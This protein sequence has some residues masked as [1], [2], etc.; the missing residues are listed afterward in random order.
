ML[1]YVPDSFG[2]SM[3][4][5]KIYRGVGIDKTVF[6][7][8]L[9]TD[10]YPHRE[11]RW[12]SEDGSDVFFYNIR[13][14]YYVGGQL[15]Y[16]DDAVSLANQVEKGCLS[17]DIALPLG[18]DQRYVDRN[19]K[20]RIEQFNQK[21]AEANVDSQL[22]ESSYDALFARL[23]A[24]DLPMD[25][26]SGEMIDGQVSKIHRSIYSSRADHKRLNDMLERR[27]TLELEPLM[28]LATRFGIGYQKELL[29]NLWRIVTRNHAHD[30]AGGCNTDK[31]NKI[32]VERFEH[33]DQM[34]SAARDY[35]V[36]KVAESQQALE[37]GARLTLF[38]TLP[39]AREHSKK[40]T[41]STKSAGFTISTLTGEPVH[42]DVIAQSQHYNGSIQ[43]DPKDNDPN[44]YYYQT[45]IVLCHS[46]PALGFTSL[47]IE[48]THDA[49]TPL[50][51]KATFHIENNRYRIEYTGGGLHLIDK[52]N[53]RR[54]DY[55]L[56]ARDG[57]DDG[58]TYDYSP[59][60]QDWVID[61]SFN[62]A[63]CTTQ[64]GT[65]QHSLTLK[66]QWM[67]P[68]NLEARAQ[69]FADTQCDYVL[70][71]TLQD[72]Q[73]LS[74]EFDINNYV[75]DHRLQ[76]VVNSPIET[77]ES[78]A[79]TPFGFVRRPHYQLQ[80]AD[81]RERGWK[82]E[83]CG[84]YPMINFVNLSDTTTSLSVL[85]QGIKEY[86]VLLESPSQP[87]GKVALT[88]FRSVGWLGKP[89]LIRR[90]GIA[91]GQ[92]YKYIPTPDSQMKGHQVAKLALL[93]DEKFD[94]AAINHASQCWSIEQPYY[95]A[96]SLNQFTNTLKYFVMHPLA[97]AIGDETS[98]LTL[99]APLLV[100]TSVQYDDDALYVRVYNPSEYA[101]EDGGT[102][103]MHTKVAEAFETNL[104]NQPLHIV[105]I[106]NNAIH[107]GAFR[108]KQIRTFKIS[109]D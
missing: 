49:Q 54:W 30:S 68:E 57:G 60:A 35:L 1:G 97:D 71:L 7:R 84:I 105:N 22:V 102:L 20:S 62:H 108:A 93:L 14:G 9:S 106:S 18:G 2:Q 56:T 78:I 17:D 34:S 23:K 82:E 74:M 48:E 103:Q 12:Q 75:E 50:E 25:V 100:C 61:L 44:G 98:L 94:A 31:T 72:G 88:V 37:S 5:P 13:D 39:F 69:R 28:A 21:L 55:F 81:W 47:V 65:L 26:L 27:I 79:D 99:N 63:E 73:P 80:M 90:P 77:K 104:M 64:C 51:E 38:N 43:R 87:S 67:L 42:F 11:G 10:V 101:V 66:G 8:G 86:E 45:D 70:T 95:Q 46:V 29:N 4:M 59:P 91:S 92:Q 33:V 3:D 40:L 109:L 107:F 58:D 85:T 6:W 24:Q 15:I 89:D 76:L 32:I 83:P 19:V 96:Q 52:H 16:S 53:E 41:L 36:R